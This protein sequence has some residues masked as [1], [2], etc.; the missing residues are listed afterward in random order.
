M[1]KHL[2]AQ[3]AAVMATLAAKQKNMAT[4]MTKAHD[5]KRTPNDTEEAEIQVIE[6]EMAKLEKNAERLRGLIKATENAENT[7]TPVAG[8]NPEQAGASA[9]GEKQPQNAG[10]NVTV[11]EQKLAPGIGFVQMAKAKALSA[12]L[13]TQGSYVSAVE[14][15]KSS[16]MHPKVVEE[17]EKAVQVMDTTNS[18]VLVPTTPLT[19][20]FVELLRA[21]TIVDKLASKMRKADFNSTIAGMATG[22]T[23]Q[24][25][26]EGEA[27]PVTNAT[28]NSVTLK[29][30]KVAGISVLTEELSR[31]NLFKADQRILDDLIESNRMLIDLTFIDD[32]AQNERRPAG[33]LNGATIT[34]VAASDATTIKAALAGLRRQFISDNLSLSDAAYIMSENRANE[35]AELETPLGA[36]VFPG[37]QADK[38]QKTINGIPVIESE[39]AGTIVELVKASEFYLADEGQVEVAYSKDATITMPDGKLVHLFQENKEAIRAERFITWAKRRQKVAAALRFA[40]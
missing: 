38:G 8:D 31:F 29:R 32:Q 18:G 2:K 39:S 9:D 20:E 36:P 27:K 6:G 24:W 17:L 28:Y 10:K 4:I 23:S 40:A 26:G 3:L 13:A 5:E 33:S 35:W 15:A 25:V 19:D 7:L 16:G 22:A 21:D 34:E 30:H 14:I 12:K 11:T 37:L 1:L